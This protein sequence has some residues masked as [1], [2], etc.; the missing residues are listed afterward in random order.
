MGV[1]Q[2]SASTHAFARPSLAEEDHRIRRRQQQRQHG[3]IQQSRDMNPR[4]KLPAIRQCA[5][6]CLVLSLADQH[7]PGLGNLLQ[8]FNHQS[9]TLAGYQRADSHQNRCLAR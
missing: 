5:Q 7:Q 9:L 8:R 4:S 1:P 6:A 3:V 2:A